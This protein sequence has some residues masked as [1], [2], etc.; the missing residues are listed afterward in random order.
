MIGALAALGTSFS[1]TISTVFFTKAT[2]AVGPATLNVTRLA[3]GAC[4]LALIVGAGGLPWPWELGTRALAFLSLSGIIGYTGDLFAFTALVR[5]GP[6]LTTLLYA[7]WPVTAAAMGWAFLGETPAPRI[8]VGMLLVTTSVIWAASA[9]TLRGATGTPGAHPSLTWKDA[10]LMLAAVGAQA[11]GFI[12]AKVGMEPDGAS[13][14][15]APPLAAGFARLLAA[16]AVTIAFDLGRGRG[17]EILAAIR[18][19]RGAVL[20]IAAATL[21]GPVIG[22]SLSLVAARHA[23]AA[24]AAPLMATNTLWIIPV[25]SLLY[26]ERIT[27]RAVFGAAGTVA[28][29]ALL[30]G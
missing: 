25:S 1:W 7:G 19:S 28:G 10:R 3:L 4:M 24:I 8:L 21:F 12:L 17:T 30:V 16:A 29:I 5:I 14:T 18:G 11:A 9:R 13:G 2:K 26:G 15:G 6:R 22:V 23:P 20:A 27:E